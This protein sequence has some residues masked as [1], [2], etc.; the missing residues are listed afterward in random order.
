MAAFTWIYLPP[1]EA[2]GEREPAV[3]EQWVGPGPGAILRLLLR[4]FRLPA[5]AGSDENAFIRQWTDLFRL[6]T[7]A[8][9]RDRLRRLA[10][11]DGR[12]CL[13]ALLTRGEAVYRLEPGGRGHR[14]VGLV[15][16]GS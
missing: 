11:Y 12:R 7:E 6:N 16:K 9:A 15:G 13:D 8:N 3:W 14:L 2:L 10:R 1:I 5:A 4:I